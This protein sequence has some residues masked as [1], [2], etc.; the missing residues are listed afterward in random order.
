MRTEIITGIDQ[1]DPQTWATITAGYPF[2]G[3]IWYRF[4]EAVLQGQGYYAI[5]YDGSTPVGGAAFLAYYREQTDIKN[6]LV[7][8]ALQFYLSRFP[9]LV[10]RTSPTTNWRGFFLPP[11]KALHHEVLAEINKAAKE[12]ARRVRASFLLTDYLEE[13]DIDTLDWGDFT[14]LKGYLEQ[15]MI[16][17]IEWDT[18]DEFL[19]AQRKRSKSFARR[20]RTHTEEA[21][22]LG[23]KVVFEPKPVHLERAEELFHIIENKY[24]HFP[25]PYAR[26]VLESVSLLPDI[27]HM[28]AYLD[29]KLILSELMLYDA[30]TQVCTPAMFGR[31]QDVPFAY[32]LTR[33]E[34]IRHA[35]EHFHAKTWVGSTGAV[36]FKDQTGFVPDPRNNLVFYP[37]S[38][39]SRM[40]AK[41]LMKFLG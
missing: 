16:M 25:Y 36:H 7:Y 2:A 14:P 30:T 24:G 18:F 1:V 15:G 38:A 37:N 31:D 17:H 6:K 13:S 33:Y 28:T 34:M 41:V 29:D 4:G 21:A 3:C 32:F 19:A 35:I 12:V 5:V 8:D 22:A 39:F 23:V 27:A 10:C 11:D 40:A 20:Y 26:A 9:L